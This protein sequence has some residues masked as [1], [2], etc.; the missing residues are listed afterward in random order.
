MA[1]R[2][3]KTLTCLRMLAT[4]SK[5]LCVFTLNCYV[6]VSA[7][8]CVLVSAAHVMFDTQAAV[9]DSFVQHELDRV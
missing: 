6:P 5:V 4:E 3:K 9:L 8:A 2:H 7:R 1:T